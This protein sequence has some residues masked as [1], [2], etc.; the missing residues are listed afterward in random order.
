VKFPLHDASVWERVSPYLDEALDLSPDERAPWVKKLIETQPDIGHLV[1]QLLSELAAL[2]ARGFLTNP[3]LPITRLD[4]FIPVLQSKLRE[5]ASLERR[6]DLVSKV[7]AMLGKAEALMIAGDAEGAVR[8]AQAALNLAIARQDWQP[9][10]V[11][12]GLAWLMLGR[13]SHAQG[14]LAQART[15]YGTAVA[16]LSNTVAA[17]HPELVRARK[18]AAASGS[19][20]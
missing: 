7:Y 18:L 4:T 11:H 17:D 15:A 13:A 5:G 19:I 20:G 2:D 12:T 6:D 14:D 10:S 9:Y 3:P 16:H 8:E 1:E